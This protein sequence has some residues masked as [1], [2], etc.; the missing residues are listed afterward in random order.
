M[1]RLILYSLAAHLIILGLIFAAPLV[2][3]ERPRSR[4]NYRVS[5]VEFPGSP[6]AT[7]VSTPALKKTVPSKKIRVKEKAARKSK[8]EVRKTKPQVKKKTPKTEE[9]AL[10][11]SPAPSP[12]AAK[13]S[14][15]KEP[16]KVKK[17]EA[18]PK[19]TPKMETLK[20]KPAER[21][22]S[23]KTPP[24]R[25]VK[26][27]EIERPNRSAVKSAASTASLGPKTVGKVSLENVDFPYSYYL[28]VMQRK[29]GER[30]QPIYGELG[31]RGV[32]R[33][34]V[35]F[36]V[37]RDGAIADLKVEKTSGS[38]FI[39]RSAVRAILEA[40]PMPPLPHEFEGDE[41]RV[42]FGFEYSGEG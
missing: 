24:S 12:A 37:L 9:T 21:K 41:L 18:E 4:E 16:D 17:A 35:Y 42:H 3:K 38:E 5:F 40:G 32:G 6:K 22:K 31:G 15:P 33:V 27:E 28:A 11:K 23:A 20:K 30:W 26:E 29:I 19:K 39:D 1:G 36:R 7:K 2:S 8:E 13:P 14:P 10:K 34:V 25:A